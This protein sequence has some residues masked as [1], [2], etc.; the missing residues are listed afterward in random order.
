V[1][2]ALFLDRDGVINVDIGYLHRPED[3]RF[4]PGIFDL[5]RA[6]NRAGYPVLVVTNQAGIGR[7]IYTEETFQVFTRWM[8]GEF[9]KH[10][11]TID[12]VY[13]CPHHPDAGVG[14]YKIQCA[15]RKPQPGMLLQARAEFDIDM[16]HSIMIGD[17]RTDLQAAQAAGVGHVYWLVDAAA[18]QPAPADGCSFVDTL[19]SVIEVLNPTDGTCFTSKSA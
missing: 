1:R 15:C 11:A 13:H 6:A 9:A 3:C 10:G 14:A 5:V 19:E 7:G 12:K 8:T 4:I 18:P 17:S 16:P 2:P